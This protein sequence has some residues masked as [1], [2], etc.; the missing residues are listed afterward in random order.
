MVYADRC[1]RCSEL[2][3]ELFKL[4]YEEGENVSSRETL[5][6]AAE[7]AQVPGGAAYVMGDE[8]TE[9]AKEMLRNPFCGEQRITQA[10]FYQISSAHSETKTYAGALDTAYWEAIF[11]ERLD[12]MDAD[13]DGDMRTY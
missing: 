6:V 10:P 1:G 11:E 2:K 13:T 9:E 3:Q 7:R 8:G 4:C 5:A 12:P